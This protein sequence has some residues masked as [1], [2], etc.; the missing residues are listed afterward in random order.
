MKEEQILCDSKNDWGTK[1][2]NDGVYYVLFD[3]WNFL[4]SENIR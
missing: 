2:K 1:F 4:L 3:A